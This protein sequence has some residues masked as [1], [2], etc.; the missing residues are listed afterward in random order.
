MRTAKQLIY[1][2]I[3]LAILVGVLVLW[4]PVNTSKC[5]PSEKCFNPV[6]SPVLEISFGLPQSFPVAGAISAFSEV[7]NSGVSAEWSYEIN[8]YDNF[9]VLVGT[10]QKKDE[11]PASSVRLVSV[12]WPQSAARVEFK[13]LVGKEL[14][15]IISPTTPQVSETLEFSGN[16]GR[17]V[18]KLQ[19]VSSANLR[20]IKIIA[21]FKDSLGDVLWVGETILSGLNPYEA[22]E[23]L[24][25]LPKDEDLL[26]DISSGSREF[27]IYPAQ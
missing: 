19:N 23:F 8:F 3:Y 26:K 13:P 6:E 1:G 25:S 12:V 10:L 22:L 17:L 21:V 18:G 16:S 20:E 4:W 11:F 7:T 14:P 9:D 2:L 5:D 27:F 24:I 15:T